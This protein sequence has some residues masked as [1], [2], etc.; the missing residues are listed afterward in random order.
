MN[1]KIK[2]TKNQ[3][4]KEAELLLK[5]LDKKTGGAADNKAFV[6]ISALAV[7]ATIEDDNL[8]K[9]LLSLVKQVKDT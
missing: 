3:I 1:E 9:R 6:A 2:S 4:A 8:A 5:K 7:A